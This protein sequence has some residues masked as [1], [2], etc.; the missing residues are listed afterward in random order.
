MRDNVQKALDFAI[1]KEVEAESFYKTWAERSVE[2]AVRRLFAELGA[3]EHDHAEMLRHVV[4][5]DLLGRRGDG[6][7]LGLSGILR[8]V[9]PSP[10]LT[11]QEALLL[12]MKRE[13]LSVRLY[14]RLA[15]L[16]GEPAALF[17]SL[18][19]VE[20]AHKQRL[21]EAYDE[22]VLREN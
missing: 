6:A 11:L 13:D 4:P 8:D 22:N 18:A 19:R 5:A 7:D 14:D 12:A 20:R 10:S 3:A 16:G 21:E 2:P 17:R 9:K 1:A 15:E